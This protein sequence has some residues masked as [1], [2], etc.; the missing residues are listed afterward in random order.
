[1]Q[2][3]FTKFLQKL[4]KSFGSALYIFIF[5]WYNEG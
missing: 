2:V 4:E 1:M 5:L 3:L